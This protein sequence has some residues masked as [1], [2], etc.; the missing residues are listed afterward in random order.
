MRSVFVGLRSGGNIG[1]SVAGRGYD[2]SVAR[3]EFAFDSLFR[4]AGLPFGI[5]PRTA[6]VDVDGTE[7]RARFGVWV[8]RTPVANVAVTQATGPFQVAKVIG[9]A[10][11]SL[12]DRGLTFATNADSGLCVRFHE[13]VRGIDPLGWIRHPALTLTVADVGGLALALGARSPSETP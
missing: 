7:L 8:V 10:H 13:P 1:A 4:A 11:L 3:F 12:V 2:R 9:P 6:W 5:S